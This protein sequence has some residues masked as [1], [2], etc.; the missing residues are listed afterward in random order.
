MTLTSIAPPATVVGPARQSLPFGLM[1]TFAT[2]PGD[3]WEAGVQW[4]ADPCSPVGGRGADS[5]DPETPTI[6]LPKDLT[7]LGSPLGLAT[8]FQVY[9]HV[10][11]SPVGMS[12]A[13]AQA[14]AEAH[15]ANGEE[16]R[17]EQAFWTGDLGNTPFL[18][19]TTTTETL[20]AETSAAGA[21]GALESFIGSTYGAVGVIHMTRQLAATLVAD[22]VLQASNGRLTTVL[23]TPVAAGSGYPGTGP[24]GEEGQWAYVTPALF[25]YRSEI[26]TSS[27]SPGDL[28][29]RSTNDLYA[30]AE[31][32]YLLGYDP[33]GVAAIDVPTTTGGGG[34]GP[35]GPSAYEIWLDAGNEGT[36]A[37]FLAS[38]VGPEGPEG[39]QGPEGPEGPQG[40]EGPA[41]AEGQQGPAGTDGADGADGTDGVVQS[42]AAGDGI[43]VDSTDPA[44][45]IISATP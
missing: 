9:G 4:E 18:Q 32:T 31:R 10:N 28:L 14:R 3:R 20:P 39:P 1:S 6:G 22:G 12:P 40:P 43:A 5:C 25:G 23:G 33:C 27:N 8:P 38:L 21:I 7:S 29:D 42:V 19:D 34:V 41:G 2:R 26:F 45:P 35:A 24:N 11:C 15:L 30:I 36:E 16:A 13:D 44:N 17:V 37:D